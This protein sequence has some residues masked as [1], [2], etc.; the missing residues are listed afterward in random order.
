MKRYRSIEYIRTPEGRVA[1]AEMAP[2]VILGRK[3]TFADTREGVYIM[4][5]KKKNGEKLDSVFISKF[6]GTGPFA[7][8]KDAIE[9]LKENIQDV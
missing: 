2:E 1:V 9:F 3:V 6:S 4:E 7:T 8:K 5:V